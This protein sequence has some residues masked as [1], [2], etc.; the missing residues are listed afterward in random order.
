MAIFTC[1]ERSF[2]MR[3][4]YVV[5][6]AA[7]VAAG[8]AGA[9][10]A[11]KLAPSSGHPGVTVAVTGSGFGDSEAVDVYVGTVD[12]ALLVTSGTGTLSGSVTIPSGAQPGADYITA[13]G[14]HSG[15]AAQ[16]PYTVTTLW[17]QFGFGASHGNWNPYENTL[18]ASN[19]NTL[20]T[21]WQFA[22]NGN[23][24]TPV[25]YDG[26]VYNSTSSGIQARSIGTGKLVWNVLSGDAFY[27]TPTVSQGV[28]YIGTINSTYSTLYALKASSGAPIWATS[29]GGS[30][31]SSVTVAN[32][33]GYVGTADDHKITA[34]SASSGATLWSYVTG[35]G[36]AGTPT[37][38]DGVVY[39]G[40]EDN[41][42]YA[43]NAATGALI[44]SYATGDEILS[45][46]AVVNGVVYFGSFDDY[47]YAVQANGAAPGT[48]LWKTDTG[49]IINTSPA[50]A[51]DTVYCGLQNGNV[52]ALDAH[53]GAINWM[54]TT[55]GPVAT[56]IVANGVVYAVSGDNS[57]YA[58]D[59]GF[60]GLLT[61][62]L[63]GYQLFG[64]L[65]VSDG[66]LYAN[67]NSSDVYAFALGAGTNVRRP[68]ARPPAIRSLHPDLT[69]RVS[70]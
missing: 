57:L 61:T 9:A 11:V 27:A 39:V 23:G 36:V 31:F 21:L 3:G 64:S 48:L 59:A 60:G 67:A 69:L 8:Q 54:F 68:V 12:T 37:V 30:A 44:W 6:L 70:H 51:Y 25:I 13:V 35:G 32:G 56:P 17:T 7:S 55:G 33:I 28:V 41:K 50:V 62:A 15:V 46:A 40:S 34:F 66:V 52:Y 49:A 65:A 19:V 42:M 10:P 53:S 20:G 45:T 5:A 24:S 16:A 38:V 58:L 4:F 29:L 1:F 18:N 14:R 22:A 26:Y 63:T 43:L 2:D 47:M